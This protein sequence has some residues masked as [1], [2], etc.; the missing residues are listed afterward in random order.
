MSHPVWVC[1]LKPILALCHFWFELSHPVWV[2]GLKLCDGLDLQAQ[3]LSHPV[4]GCGLKLQS[5]ETASLLH[6]TPCMGVW[7]ETIYPGEPP[8]GRNVT[9][10]MG[11][12]I[13]T[14]LD[15]P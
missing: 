9:P 10:C 15:T 11:V 3:R 14:D 5:V 6:V 1:G 2:C 7:I 8:A 12:W 4:W 13:E